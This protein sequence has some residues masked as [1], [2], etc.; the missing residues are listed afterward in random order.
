[1]E[2][3]AE[4]AMNFSYMLSCAP[5]NSVIFWINKILTFAI[6]ENYMIFIPGFYNDFIVLHCIL[7]I[8]HKDEAEL[9]EIHANRDGGGVFPEWERRKSVQWGDGAV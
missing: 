2:H 4:L 9:C 7:R 6:L 1:M 5:L 8:R 3:L